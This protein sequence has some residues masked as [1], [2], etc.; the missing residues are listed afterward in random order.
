M[1]D[2][3]ATEKHEVVVRHSH[4]REG[5]AGELYLFDGKEVMLLENPAN[6]AAKVKV[7]NLTS[8]QSQTFVS[9]RRLQVVGEAEERVVPVGRLEPSAE[10]AIRGNLEELQ[11]QVRPS[12]SRSGK[13]RTGTGLWAFS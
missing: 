4:F 9:V 1:R 2:L 12:S 13:R 5:E 10:S 3:F 11:K 7:E 6:G 8:S